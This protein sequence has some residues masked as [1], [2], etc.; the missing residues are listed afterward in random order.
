[1]LGDFSCIE[2]F[3]PLPPDYPYKIRCLP[4]REDT[5]LVECQLPRSRC[6]SAATTSGGSKSAWTIILG[7]PDGNIGHSR[8]R[9]INKRS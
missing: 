4:G 2:Q 7:G 1:M 5:P 3:F 8:S 6:S 9:L